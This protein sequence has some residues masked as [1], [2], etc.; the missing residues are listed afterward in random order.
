MSKYSGAKYTGIDP[1]HLSDGSLIM[2]GEITDLLS[3]EAAINDNNFEPIYGNIKKVNKVE[4]KQEKKQ[5]IKKS[6]KKRGK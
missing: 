1:I 3:E 2:N 5:E 6:K 4:K